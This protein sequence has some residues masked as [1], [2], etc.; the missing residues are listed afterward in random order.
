MA[1]RPIPPRF[2]GALIEASRD[3]RSGRFR[4]FWTTRENPDDPLVAALETHFDFDGGLPEAGCLEALLDGALV[5]LPATGTDSLD[6]LL[7]CV[8]YRLDPSWVRYH[9]E[10]RFD[11]ALRARVLRQSLASVAHDL[12]VLVALSLLLT[13]RGGL[14]A[15]PSN[16]G[17]LNAKR[18]RL[19]R[20]PLLEHVEVSVPVFR[21]QTTESV[22][23]DGDWRRAPRFHHVR[24]HLVRR[25][26]AVF[27][28]APHWRGHL[29]LGRIRTRTVVVDSPVTH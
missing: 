3:G 23:A 24:G 21:T 10:D 15:A 25:A 4:T 6:P 27:W 1:M 26:N 18:Q 12:P 11:P 17:R 13:V 19:G 8:R 16:L 22:P 20:A 7:R 9:R 2:S 28:R 14:P 29:R 5:G